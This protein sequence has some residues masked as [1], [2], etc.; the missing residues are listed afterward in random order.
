MMNKND[1][2]PIVF[3]VMGGTEYELEQAREML[4]DTEICTS[5]FVESNTAEHSLNT[6]LDQGSA[7]RMVVL[8]THENGNIQNALALAKLAKERGLIAVVKTSHC[9]RTPEEF[10]A[11]ESLTMEHLASCADCVLLNHKNTLCKKNDRTQ[12]YLDV[13][14]FQQYLTAMLDGNNFICLD[15]E[16]ISSVLK[17]SGFAYFG[18]ASITGTDTAERKTRIECMEPLPRDILAKAKGVIMHIIGS[19]DIGLEEVEAATELIQPQTHPDA[20]IVFGA[21]FDD[22]LRSEVQVSVLAAGITAETLPN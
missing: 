7:C 22:E 8:V 13:R 3:V 11:T 10:L 6:A 14:S 2:H 18:A 19:Y 17:E 20:I 21:A 9:G 1:M 12:F 4:P 16:D 5:I 15:F